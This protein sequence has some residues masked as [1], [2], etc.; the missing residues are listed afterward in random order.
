MARWLAASRPPRLAERHLESRA[1]RSAHFDDLKRWWAIVNG[2]ITPE[3][4]SGDVITSDLELLSTEPG[5]RQFE[6]SEPISAREPM[7]SKVGPC[8][9]YRVWRTRGREDG[10]FL[11]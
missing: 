4:E 10:Q 1:R 2:K 6:A 11:P 5:P 7:R 3:V 9:T 8:F